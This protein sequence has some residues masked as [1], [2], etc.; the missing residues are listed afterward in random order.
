MEETPIQVGDRVMLRVGHTRIGEVVH[1]GQTGRVRNRRLPW[2]QPVA[3]VRWENGGFD[4]FRL[5][6]LQKMEPADSH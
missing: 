4:S 6:D 3:K 1:V 2:P 5:T